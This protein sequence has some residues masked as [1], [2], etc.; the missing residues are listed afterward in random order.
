MGRSHDEF[1]GLESMSRNLTPATA[2]GTEVDVTTSRPSS[3]NTLRR[4][5]EGRVRWGR[6][7]RT[8]ST[9]MS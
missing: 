9:P 8:Y 7:G 2:F 6:R 1:E 3:W 4:G 5:T